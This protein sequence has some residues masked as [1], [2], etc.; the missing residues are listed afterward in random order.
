MI[1]YAKIWT[2]EAFTT[3]IDYGDA[4]TVRYWKVLKRHSNGDVLIERRGARA[5]LLHEL[6]KDNEYHSEPSWYLPNGL[7]LGIEYGYRRTW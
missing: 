7:H 4:G 3:M 1:E 5:Y 2:L 6:V